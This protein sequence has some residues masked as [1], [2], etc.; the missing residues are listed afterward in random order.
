MDAGVA[1][2]RAYIRTVNTYFAAGY[3]SDAT[4]VTYL[5]KLLKTDEAILRS[6][7]VPQPAT[8]RTVRPAP[9]A[10]DSGLFWS[11]DAV[12]DVDVSRRSAVTAAP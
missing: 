9:P 1:L 10:F 12:Q 11:C 3:K 6:T 2:L 7:P 8:G 4:F 5:A